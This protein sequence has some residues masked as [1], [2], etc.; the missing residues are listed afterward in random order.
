MVGQAQKG[1]LVEPLCP[2]PKR[3]SLSRLEVLAVSLATAIESRLETS[4]MESR[5]KCPISNRAVCNP[6]MQGLFLTIGHCCP[7]YC[8]R[9]ATPS[10]LPY[11]ST[12]SYRTITSPP[13]PC[14][15]VTCERTLY[16]IMR[17]TW[18]YM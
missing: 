3:S 2:A 13:F 12:S 17:Y 9:S 4:M 11:L 18:A 5:S 16:S 8:R 6:M 14:R 10:Y 1:L 7:L 15:L